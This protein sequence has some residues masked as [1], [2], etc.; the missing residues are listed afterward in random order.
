MTKIKLTQC[1]SMISTLLMDYG[2]FR[3]V[4]NMGTFPKPIASIYPGRIA[5]SWPCTATTFQHRNPPTIKSAKFTLSI[6]S[7]T[8]YRSRPKP[9]RFMSNDR[10][11]HPSFE[12]IDQDWNNTLT[13]CISVCY[14]RSILIIKPAYTLY[15][16]Y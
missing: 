6:I 1:D 9:N 14:N 2:I 10:K 15:G 5:M 8:L 3:I 12:K 7:L 16:K 4:R 13:Y 11:L